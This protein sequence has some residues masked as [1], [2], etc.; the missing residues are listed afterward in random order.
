MIKKVEGAGMSLPFY[1]SASVSCILHRRIP[2]SCGSACGNCRDVG[3][4]KKLLSVT[5]ESNS[6][7]GGT[8]DVGGVESC[9]K[10]CVCSK[11]NGRG[12]ICTCGQPKEIIVVT[13]VAVYLLH[14]PRGRI[15]K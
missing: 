2:T 12:M 9:L 3:I 7:S 15:Y 8:V 13:L 4:K 5:E 14:V 1:R 6:M 10:V 11:S